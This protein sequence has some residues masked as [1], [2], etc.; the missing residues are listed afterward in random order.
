MS[1]EISENEFSLISA[2]H[3][4]PFGWLLNLKANGE[5][6]RSKAKEEMHKFVL[7]DG[8]SYFCTG[9]ST[10]NFTRE[11]DAVLVTSSQLSNEHRKLLK[12]PGDG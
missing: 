11:Y 9:Y 8:H 6:C 2:Y 5:Y 7:V 1:I 3:L 4:N 10:N 12:K